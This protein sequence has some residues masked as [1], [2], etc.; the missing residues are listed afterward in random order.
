[1]KQLSV[2]AVVVTYN[3]KI[4]LA[5]CLQALSNQSRKLD[6]IFIIDN[7]STDGTFEYLRQNDLL[8]NSVVQF[9]SL[10]SNQ[11]GAGGFS[12]GL[13]KAF[14]SGFD[15]VWLMDDDG[16]PSETCLSD[17][18]E[19]SDD[20]TYLGPLVLDIKNP[21]F[22]CFPMR[23]PNSLDV[24]TNLDDLNVLIEKETIEGI[25]IPFN[26]ILLSAQLIKKIGFPKKEYFI[27]GDDIEYTLRAK[28]MG[29]RIATINSAKFY[30]PKEKSLGTSM[31]FG[32]LK[33]NDTPSELK[34]Y[35]MC[36][37]SVVNHRVY[38]GY[39][40]LFAFMF[41]PIWF[42]LFTKPNFKRLA[43]SIRAM[44]H[45]LKKNFSYHRTLL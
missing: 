25:V 39:L 5:R 17:L 40:H 24:I 34:L 28:S 32:L 10:V 1:M 36:R 23:I 2:C 31:F 9:E 19:F 12:Y 43:L 4:L 22:L 38:N 29:A 30:H 16:F 27:W 45:K 20:N 3:R 7:A 18:L 8:S 15:Y 14:N 42:Y 44:W 6:A 11:G 35:C 41:K 21:E 33:F 37:N 26:G 13:E